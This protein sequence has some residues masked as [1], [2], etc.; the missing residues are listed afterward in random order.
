[1]QIYI[2]LKDKHT[3]F[4]RNIIQNISETKVYYN[5]VK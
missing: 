2:A 3:L 4:R 5:T 1:M